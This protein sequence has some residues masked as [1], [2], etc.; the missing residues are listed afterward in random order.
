VSELALEEGFDFLS[1]EY[2]QLFENSGATAFQH[3][4]WLDRLYRRLAP[5]LDAEPVV[6]TARDASDRL[7]MVLPLMRRRHRGL[8]LIEF[9]DLQVSDYAWPVC[10]AMT[11]SALTKDWR[12]RG[13]IREL[14]RPY[15]II[16][17]K[18][19]P[20]E[21]PPLERLF[22][23]SRRVLMGVNAHA[24]SLHKS[25]DSWRERAMPSSYAGEL[26]R[27]RRRLSRDGE[28]TYERLRD[29]ARIDEALGWLRVWRAERFP[30]DLLQQDRYFG[31]YQEIATLG[32][33]S[34]FSRT[35]RLALSDRTIATV[36]C[37][38]NRKSCM[39]LIS[40]FD[41]ANYGRRSIGA[42]A[43]QDLARDC[44]A[45]GDEVLDFTIGDESYKRLFGAKPSPMGMISVSGT[46][47]GLIAN[48]VIPRP[49]PPEEADQ[50]EPEEETSTAPPG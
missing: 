22:G 45:E 26:E 35:Y 50:R 40:G 29:P 44:I 43:Y 47:L 9:A 42:L 30:H 48:S 34:G 3:P 36:W 27:K 38:H 33:E 32:A 28:L 10:D 19:I 11:L 7:E 18:K 6:I 2:R 12:T 8:R 15:D 5:A 21:A 1:P 25:F 37:L 20:D 13:R 46:P 39:M 16:R 17:I 24:S 41:F 49:V 14:L 23:A 31:F 4:L